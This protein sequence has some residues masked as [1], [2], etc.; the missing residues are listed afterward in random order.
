[1]EYDVYKGGLREAFTA[2][3]AALVRLKI[4]RKFLPWIKN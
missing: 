4:Q 3:I 2:D 1:M